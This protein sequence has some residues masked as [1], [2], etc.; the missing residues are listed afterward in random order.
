MSKNT[1]KAIDVGQSETEGSRRAF[2]KK[3]GKFAVYTP[4]TVMMLM[5]PS[6]AHMSKS[7]VGR[8]YRVKGNNGIGNGYDHQPPGNPKPNDTMGVHKGNRPDTGDRS[9]GFKSRRGHHD[10]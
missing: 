7:M 5:K 8:P 9:Y 10:D 4:P 6:Y 2:L 3:A 1:D